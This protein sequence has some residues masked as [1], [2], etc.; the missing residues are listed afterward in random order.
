VTAAEGS[1]LN[2]NLPFL[3]CIGDDVTV[4]FPG[5]GWGSS[6]TLLLTFL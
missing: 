2:T 4:L 5:E 6:K 3:I 1:A